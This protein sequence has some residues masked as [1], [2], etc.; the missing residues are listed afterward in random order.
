MY[1][2]SSAEGNPVVGWSYDGV[3]THRRWTLEVLDASQ[4]LV[5]FRNQSSGTLASAKGSTVGAPVV[6]TQGSYYF[7]LIST[8]TAEYQIQLPFPADPLNWR[9][10]NNTSNTPIVLATPNASDNNQLWAFIAI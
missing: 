5:A 10:A 3:D 6:G 2:G 9:L 1:N 7:R 8:R 4:G